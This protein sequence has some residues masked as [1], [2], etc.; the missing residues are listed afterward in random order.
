MRALGYTVHDEEDVAD[1]IEDY[2]L[3]YLEEDLGMG[4]FVDLAEGDG[5]DELSLQAKLSFYTEDTVDMWILQTPVSVSEFKKYLDELAVRVARKRILVELPSLANEADHVSAATPRSIV[6]ILAQL[7]GTTAEEVVT[8]LG[9]DW[10]AIR[11]DGMGCASKPDRYLLWDARLVVGI[12]DQHV[13]I[14]MPAGAP[15]DVD[16]N[17]VISWFELGDDETMAFAI[18]A[19]MLR[20]ASI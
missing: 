8:E 1:I 20:T 11:S 2:V 16:S 14:F 12:D 19:H 10:Q 13:H 7:F 17:D 4:L 5:G 15:E 6:Q 18:F 9:E 3:G